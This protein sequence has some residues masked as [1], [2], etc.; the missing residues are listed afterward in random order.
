M[1]EKQPS[2]IQMKNRAAIMDAALQVF[3]TEGFRGATLDQ[4][5]G[6]SG[7]SKPNVLYYF[8]SKEAMYE[9]LLSTLLD[10]WLEPLRQV[11]GDGDPIEELVAYIMLKLKM[12]RDLPRES[13]LFANEILR[14]APNIIGQIEGPLRSLVDEKAELIRGWSEEGRIAKLDPYHLIFSIWAT[15]QHYAD[16]DVQVR[17]ILRR[18]DQAHLTD[19]ESFLSEF[20]RRALTP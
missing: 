10:D 18:E 8:S 19:A 14:G 6:A 17:G 13:R 9:A 3:S 16:F 20:Y 7:L 11:N 1:G 15:T 12:S 5:A 2:R 4:I